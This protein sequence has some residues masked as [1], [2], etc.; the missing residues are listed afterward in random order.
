MK[1][2]LFLI[3]ALMTMSMAHSQQPAFLGIPVGT[4]IDEFINQLEQ[5]GYTVRG[6]EKKVNEERMYY[7]YSGEFQGNYIIYPATVTLTASVLTRTVTKVHVEFYFNDDAAKADQVANI[8]SL[9]EKKYGKG[10]YYHRGHNQVVPTLDEA[11]IARW[12]MQGKQAIVMTFISSKCLF[13]F[14]FED[15][16]L[17]EQEAEQKKKNQV[18]EH[19]Q[20]LKTS[21]NPD[22]Y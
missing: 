18:A 16:P 11:N 20:L 4:T 8:V 17:I 1:K 14:G 12:Y 21:V 2:I 7:L 19:K 10:E 13:D 15:N 22:E 9:F 3:V 6:S 5:Q